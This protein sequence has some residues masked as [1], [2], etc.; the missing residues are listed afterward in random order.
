MQSS[1]GLAEVFARVERVEWLY[2][3]LAGKVI[4]WTQQHGGTSDDPADQAFLVGRDGTVVA[5]CPDASVHAAASF[6]AWLKAQVD[7]YEKEHPRT[8]MPFVGMDVVVEELAGAKKVTC[9]DFDE[10]LTAKRPILVYV[11]RERAA[12]GDKA[13]KAEVAAARK[14]ERGTLDAKAPAEAAAGWRLLRLDLS[15]EADRLFHLA[16]LAKSA[17]ALVYVPVV[18]EQGPQPEVLAKDISAAALAAFLKK[19]APP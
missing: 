8:R 9:K 13:A 18:G 1:A 15:K 11:G 17:P 14:F 19:N 4:P 3:G 12:E 2:D 7:A 16:L 5:R 10:A 6:G